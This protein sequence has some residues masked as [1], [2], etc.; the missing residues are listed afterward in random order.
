MRK[1]LFA[2]L[3]CLIFCT[4]CVVGQKIP[5]TYTPE[6]GK[7]VDGSTAYA[8]SISVTDDRPYVV[9][10]RKDS[11][12]IGK[13]RGGFG[14]P[15]DVKTEDKIPLALSLQRDL[16][17][18]LRQAGF[19]VVTAD[20]QRRLVISIKDYNF[21]CFVNCRVWHNLHVEVKDNA[22]TLLHSRDVIAEQTVSGHVL[23][24]PL[25]VMKEEMPKIYG[26]MI[27]EIVRNDPAL[28]AALQRSETPPAT[29]QTNRKKP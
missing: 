23:T 17:I 19:T 21:D 16:A 29:A 1:S 6:G 13:Y 18:E 11:S 28:L 10:G 14:N 4:G 5:Y 26:K 3:C 27:R 20:A 15:W 22:G 9:S 12:F 25:G 7:T 8:V 24:G 2:L